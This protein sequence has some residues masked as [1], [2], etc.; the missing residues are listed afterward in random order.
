MSDAA[1]VVLFLGRVL[2]VALFLVSAKGHIKQGNMMV[3]Y[4]KAKK[5]PLA[6]LA[7][8][9]AGVYQIAAS[10]LIAMGIWPDIGAIMLGIYVI[11]AALYF[12]NYWTVQDPA[13]R[14]QEQISFYRNVTLLGV[15]IILF[16]LFASM[17][18][19]IR[20]ALTGPLIRF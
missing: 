19:G 1:G 18:D 13:Q 9:H 10:L 12:H 7:G 6:T 20:F 3:G 11:P 2:F 8:W 15:V 17:G 16:A 4:A 5:M 14:Q